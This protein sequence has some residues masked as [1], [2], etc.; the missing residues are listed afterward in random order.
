M[1]PRDHSD[2]YRNCKLQLFYSGEKIFGCTKAIICMLSA[3]TLN[4]VQNNNLICDCIPLTDGRLN[5]RVFAWGENNA[6]QK[7][8]Q[9]EL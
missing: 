1:L 9:M 3:C 7:C 4:S 2:F 8:K 5:R 6:D